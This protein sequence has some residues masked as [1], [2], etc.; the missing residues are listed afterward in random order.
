M[1][2]IKD[3]MDEWVDTK[4]LRA[5]LELRMDGSTLQ[6]VELMGWQQ[7]YGEDVTSNLNVSYDDVSFIYSP[8]H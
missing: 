2:H 1:Q 3:N 5:R 8:I 7:F 4:A 6:N